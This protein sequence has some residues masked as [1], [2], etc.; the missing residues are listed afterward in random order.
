MPTKL[1]ERVQQLVAD[2]HTD[3][4][5]HLRHGIEKESLRVNK[6]GLLSYQPHPSTLG[7]ALTHSRITTDY[8][9][10]LL[11]FITPVFE[12]VEEAIAY[13]ADLHRFTYHRLG[14]ELLWNASMPCELG[15]TEDIPIARYGDSNIGRMK[16]IYRVGLEHRY[17]KPMQTIAGI[18]YNFSLPD[19]F[20]SVFRQ[21]QA[22]AGKP[23][24]ESL[25][26]F[27]SDSYFALIRNFRR[28]SWLLIY[29]FGASPAVNRSFVDRCPERRAGR[30][31]A[32]R[33]LCHQS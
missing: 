22:D 1:H 14:D 12:H 29:L 8:S 11:E 4:F 3:L 30:R 5:N 2:G 21:L 18:H 7:S 28:Y 13:L 6:Q 31:Y 33:P 32:V 26:D 9:E 10:A 23:V 24:G 16:Y 19:A 20:W 27:Q 25:Q 15:C 17:G